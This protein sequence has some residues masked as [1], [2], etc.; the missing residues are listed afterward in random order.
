MRPSGISPIGDGR[1]AHASGIYPILGGLVFRH[2]VDMDELNEGP[3]EILDD[4]DENTQPNEEAE[5]STAGEEP[6]SAAP[7]FAARR[8]ERTSDG[9]ILAGVA[10]GIAEYFRI[11]VSLVRIAFVLLS[12]FGGVGVV[13]YASGWLLMP[14]HRGPSVSSAFL[15]SPRR[16]GAL[17][18]VAVVVGGI[19]LVSLIANGP[20]W[21]FGGPFNRPR[22]GW[23]IVLA[24]AGFLVLRWL[25]KPH[26]RGTF[27]L[28][29]LLR[30]VTLLCAGL[31]GLVA[32]STLVAVLV[33]GVSLRGGIGSK[34]YRPTSLTQL[35]TTYRAGIGTMTLDLRALPFPT[36]SVK[37]SASVAIGLLVIEVPNDIQVSL[38]ARSGIGDVNYG[39]GGISAFDQHANSSAS[40][41][42]LILDAEAGIGQVDLI[43]GTSAANSA[44]LALPAALPTPTLPFAP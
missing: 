15:S 9:R 35:Q 40:H 34:E 44:P 26:G 18:V 33:T 36:H 7:P 19:A 27:S 3:T 31:V 38:S 30:G 20:I 12:L 13:L 14:E 41:Q 43:R 16:H 28:G 8:L 25:A 29:R 37:V 11:D 2:S 21:G 1:Q 42:L 6:D 4:A 23:I 39:N 17:A 32:L 10:G 5:E 24:V 22:L